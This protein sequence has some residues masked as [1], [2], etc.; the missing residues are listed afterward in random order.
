[1]K[2]I[3]VQNP[4][5]SK[6]RACPHSMYTTVQSTWAH[7]FEC[8]NTSQ[9][10]L[11][12]VKPVCKTNLETHHVSAFSVIQWLIPSPEINHA[13]YKYVEKVDGMWRSERWGTKNMYVLNRDNP[14]WLLFKSLTL[15]IFNIWKTDTHFLK[16]FYRFN[17]F[18][19]GLIVHTVEYFLFALL[20]PS[21]IRKH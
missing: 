12:Q 21:N 1:M 2:I 19:L 14:M 8:L 9:L 6:H 5:A 18:H 10:C 16:S 7:I 20:F 3:T 4:A 13:V 15:Y 11:T 17:T